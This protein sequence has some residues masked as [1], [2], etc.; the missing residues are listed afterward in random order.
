DCSE[1]EDNTYMTIGLCTSGSLM[2]MLRHRRRFAEPEA[3]FFMVR[4]T[5]A[6]PYMH[7]RQVIQHNLKLGNPF[8]DADMNVRVGDFGLAALIESPGE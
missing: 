8:L 4:L 1:D 2:D 5:G 6:C 7:T 3:R